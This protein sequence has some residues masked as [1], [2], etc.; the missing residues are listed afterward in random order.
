VDNISLLQDSCLN[1]TSKDIASVLWLGWLVVVASM[2][3]MEGC[4]TIVWHVVVASM[5]GVVGL[6]TCCGV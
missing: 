1:N 6:V 5:V 3:R 4:Q 2:L